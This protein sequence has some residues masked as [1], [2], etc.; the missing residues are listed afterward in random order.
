[1]QHDSA[2]RDPNLSA[3]IGIDVAKA[4]LDCFFDLSGQHFQLANDDN[5]IAQLLSHLRPLQVH[6]VVIEATGRLHRQVAAEL[7][8][9]G[10]PVALVNPQRAREYAHSIGKLE[11]TDRVD[12]TVLAGFGRAAQHHI[13]QKPSEKQ[14]ELNDLISRRRALVQMRV[15][16][17]NRL[18]ES[19][20][21][22][23]AKTQAK[24]LLRLIDQQVQD[25]DRAIAK[26]IDSEDHWKR[27]SEIITSIPGVS[28]GTANQLLADLPELGEL[29]RQRIAKLAG[30]A[31]LANDS[32]PRRGQRSIKGGRQ[33]VR[34]ALYMAAFNAIRY[35]DRFKQFAKRLT[36]AGKPFKVVVTATMRK[37]LITLNQMVKTNSVYNPKLVVSLP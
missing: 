26:L 23:L 35:C 4:T 1:M 21:P 24:Q 18:A 25:I 28:T 6:L 5:G 29:N 19:Q 32:G 31:P 10:I 9:A 15:A 33:P 37:L 14:V 17:K 20:Q 2:Q 3:V 16:E 30:V 12:A 7:L 34:N 13:L 22:K 8:Q 11:K 27:K 36:D